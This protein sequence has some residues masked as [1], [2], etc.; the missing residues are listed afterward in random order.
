MKK[1]EEER[2]GSRG[3][4]SQKTSS[5]GQRYTLP[6]CTHFGNLKCAQQEEAGAWLGGTDVR[7]FVCSFV[8]LLVRSFVRTDGNSPP[9][10]YRTSSPLG[11]LPKK[12]Q[13]RQWKRKRIKRQRDKRYIRDERD[14]SEKRDK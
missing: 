8:R 14:K 2:G 1:G 7:S 4:Q 5:S 6:C 10:F 3:E 13:K 12:G 9:L 11:P